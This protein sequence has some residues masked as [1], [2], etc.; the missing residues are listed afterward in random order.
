MVIRFPLARD[1]RVKRL[2]GKRY[3]SEGIITQHVANS[4]ASDLTRYDF[5]LL[6]FDSCQSYLGLGIFAASPVASL[7]FSSHGSRSLDLSIVCVIPTH[8]KWR[9][10]WTFSGQ[11]QTP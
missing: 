5:S 9:H 8:S 10:P 6:P 1:D 4:T 11:Y 7:A 3:A 2:S